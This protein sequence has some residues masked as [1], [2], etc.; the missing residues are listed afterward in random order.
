MPFDFTDEYLHA[1]KFLKE[2]LIYALIIFAPDWSLAFELMCDASN[3]GVEAVLGQR[4]D[5]VLYVIYYAS[6]V[7]NNA[8][9]NYTTIEK[10][11]LAVVFTFDKFISYLVGSKV[12]VYI[13]Y[14]ALK[15][16]LNKYDGKP[17]QICWILLLQEFDLEI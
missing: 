11:L 14:V 17:R 2:K 1:F 3:I 16:L 15:Y 4:K 9:I 5:K 10:E 8:Q 6:H 7:L 12:I 13:N